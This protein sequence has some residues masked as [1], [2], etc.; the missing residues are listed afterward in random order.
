MSRIQFGNCSRLL[1][2]KL[3]HLMIHISDGSGAPFSSQF[4]KTIQWSNLHARL[5]ASAFSSPISQRPQQVT[6]GLR[7]PAVLSSTSI[8]QL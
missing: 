1:G 5:S 2:L 8:L 3:D 6:F 4:H 7:G